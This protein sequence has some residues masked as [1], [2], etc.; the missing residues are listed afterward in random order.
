MMVGKEA[1]DSYWCHWCQLGKPEWQTWPYTSTTAPTCWTIEEL[2]LKGQEYKGKKQVHDLKDPPL[3]DCI[4]I[5]RYIVPAL[6][7]QLGF[8]IRI[9][10]VFFLYVAVHLEEKP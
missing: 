1:G 2:V 6:H 7:L 8:G 10:K 5:K 4:R 3:F 9:L